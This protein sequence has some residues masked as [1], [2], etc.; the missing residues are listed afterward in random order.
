MEQDIMVSAAY[1]AA[2]TYERFFVKSIYRF[3]TPLLLERAA[4]K[5]GETVLDVACGTG[6]VARSV[7]PLVG[8]AGR[9]VGLDINPSML[10]VACKQFSDNCEAIDWRE[11]R[12]EKLP[13]SDREFHLVTCQQG[14][15]FFNRPTAVREM[16]RVLRGK[17]RVAIAVWRS[18][19]DNL[20]YRTIFGAL[21]SVFNIPMVELANPF[22]YGDQDELR[23]LL[24]EAGFK[25]VNIEAVRHPVYF[26]EVD[27]FMET[28][29]RAASVVIPAFAAMDGEM[30]A[31][32]MSK[33]N[34]Q[35]ADYLMD[36]TMGGVLSF[37]MA[38]NIG[39]GIK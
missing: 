22:S 24:I 17:G 14:M 11:G 31:D 18:L 10:E 37:T 16:R 12:A 35:V 29:V 27:H 9:V 30:R 5:A 34:Q 4:P 15:Q 6:V 13:F 8:E 20:F 26:H 2:E 1:K 23:D 3:W 19:D 36:H 38:A 33:V 32:L 39:V 25:R 21:A 28:T 7:V